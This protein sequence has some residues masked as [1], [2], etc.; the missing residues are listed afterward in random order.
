MFLSKGGPIGGSQRQLLYLLDHL[1]K[2]YEPIVV[3]PLAGELTRELA[4][5]QIE[6][7]EFPLPPWR[8][9]RTRLRR[10]S[11]LRRL[12]EI[13]RT[14]RGRLVHCSDLWMH[15]YAAALR[16]HSRIPVILHVRAPVSPRDVDKHSLRSADALIAISDR[17]RAD[18]LNAGLS[19]ETVTVI[20][21]SVD[22]DLFHPGAG[23]GLLQRQYHADDVLKIGLVGRIQPTKRQ[24][25]FLSAVRRMS[26]HR[27]D[28]CVFLIGPVKD[29]DYANRIRRDVSSLPPSVRVRLTGQT[30][31]LPAILSELDF[32]VT[33][34]GG[35]VIY[36][37]LACETPVISAFFTRP[38]NACILRHNETGLLVPDE[39]IEQ[40]ADAMLRLA[41]DPQ[42][43]QTLGR[44]GRRRVIEELSPRRLAK[45]VETL[46][47]SL[48]RSAAPSDKSDVVPKDD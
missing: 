11:A 29:P 5:R 46:Y 43:R 25:D 31:R 17:I 12:L 33:L 45:T 16:Q 1:G 38:E 37:A 39:S 36:E 48:L 24:L 13:C 44:Q 26:E 47:D 7:R 15:G 23:E 28:L 40:L 10:R 20:R 6:C 42:Q 19:P 18:L 35:S 3:C 14:S 4:A 2:N 9:W 22:T 27:K 32:L 8:K 34:T 41:A 30:D 21:D